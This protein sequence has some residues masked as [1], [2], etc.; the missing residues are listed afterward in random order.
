[1][2]LLDL[3]SKLIDTLRRGTPL[4]EIY[5]KAQSLIRTKRPDLEKHFVKNCGFVVSNMTM[6]SK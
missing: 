2:F 4:N 6:L 1:M 3:Q 5:G